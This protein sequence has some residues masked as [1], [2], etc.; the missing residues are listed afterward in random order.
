MAITRNGRA[1]FW[2]ENDSGVFYEVSINNSTGVGVARKHGAAVSGVPSLSL[3]ETAVTVDPASLA[4]W[5]GYS[6]GR[7]VRAAVYNTAQGLAAVL[8]DAS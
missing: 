8:P 3:A 7:K 2:F 4:A 6:E 1:T 5:Q